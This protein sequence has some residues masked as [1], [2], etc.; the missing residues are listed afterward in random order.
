[1]ALSDLFQHPSQGLSAS[2]LSAFS[3]SSN[4]WGLTS[5]PPGQ[6]PR[7]PVAV[8]SLSLSCRVWVSVTRVKSLQSCATLLHYGLYPARLLCPWDSPGKNTGVGCHVLQGIFLNQGLNPYLLH[9]PVLAGRLFATSATWEAHQ[10][11]AC[12]SSSAQ[13]SDDFTLGTWGLLSIPLCWY[14]P[15][16]LKHWP[17]QR[18][19][20]SAFSFLPDVS[21][22]W[23]PWLHLSSTCGFLWLPILWGHLPP[24]RQSQRWCFNHLAKAQSFNHLLILIFPQN[25]KLCV[26]LTFLSGFPAHGGSN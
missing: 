5:G 17:S 24:L 10:V 20:Y 18:G 11:L 22:L 23:S 19:L 4:S 2:G 15:A 1:M 7:F 13:F 3:C 21:S 16:S 25:E 14:P 12:G 26:L 6:W 9:L 8:Q